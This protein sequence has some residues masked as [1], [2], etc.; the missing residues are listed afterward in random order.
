MRTNI[1]I[2]DDLLKEA[3]RS[4]GEKTKKAVVE[5][6]LRK[7]VQLQRQTSIRKLRGT[8]KWEGNLEEMRLSRFVDGKRMS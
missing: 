3:M 2:D 4:S 1:E 8:L 6:G 7:L 5:A